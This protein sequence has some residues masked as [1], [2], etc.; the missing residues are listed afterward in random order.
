MAKP[1]YFIA[2]PFGGRPVPVDWHLT[3]RSLL[4]PA[5]SR[6]V[7][8]YKRSYIKANGEMSVP[9][10]QAQT[11]LVEEA[12]N[13][14]AEYILFIEDDT[15][16][17]P[18]VILELG[19]VLETAD[20]S[21]MVCGGIYT[22]RSNPPEPILYAA[23]MEG[24]FWNWKVG[25]IFP[26]WAVGMGCTMIKVKL[27]RMMS[28]PWFK[29]IKNLEEALEYPDL[30]PDIDKA[31]QVTYG[32]KVRCGSDMFFYTKLAAMGFKVLAH[33]GVLPVHWDIKENHG[34]WLP[35]NTPPTEGVMFNGTEFGWTDPKLERV[36]AEC[37]K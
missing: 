11:E 13:Q 5:N 22:T 37:L 2:Y 29:E 3:V 34:Y 36:G 1:K 31:K 30:F 27:F 17:P 26:C 20:E 16:P 32:N 33:G 7:E 21:V 4:L 35:K 15:I 10:D 9:T 8:G 14:D 18:N 6:V 19:R 25:Q 23:P 28:K 24:C 12:L